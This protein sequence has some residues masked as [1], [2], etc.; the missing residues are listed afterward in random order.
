MVEQATSIQDL[1]NDGNSS[2][3]D[4]ELVQSI[5]HEMKRDESPQQPQGPTPEEIQQMQQMQQM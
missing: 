3:N 1:Q 5:L 2:D 4:T